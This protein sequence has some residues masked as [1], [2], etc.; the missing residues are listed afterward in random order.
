MA[1]DLKIVGG[2]VV[3]GRGIFVADIGVTGGRITQIGDLGS[4][5]ARETVS[6]AG[7]HILPGGIDTQV[8]FRE[9][10][11]EHKEDIESGTRS[12]I[13]GG[14][15]TI[16]EM[17]NTNPA[18]T[19]A[20]ALSDKLDRANGRAWCD[21]AF[22]VGAAKDNAA[23]LGRLELLPGTPGVKIFMGSSTG[24]LLVDDD[25]SLRQVLR[26]YKTRSPI[27]AEDEDR[28]NERKGIG[29]P[30]PHVREHPNRRDP[31]C[32]RIA[33]ERILRLS[34]ETYHPVHVLHISTADE[35]PLLAEAKRKG[36]RTTCEVTPQH[37]TLNEEAYERIGTLAQMNP[38]V[39]DESHRLA[40]WKAV[41][42]G[43]FD[44][45]GSDH[46]PHTLEEKSK[47]FP[48]SP[49]GMPGVQTMLPVFLEW[50]HRG[51]LPLIQLVQMLCE[52]PA[53]LYGIAGKGRIE[54]GF[55]ADL[56]LVDLNKE[57]TIEKDWLQSKCGWSPFE[58][59]TVHGRIE[60]VYL[61]G[62]HQVRDRELV[63]TQSGTP[64]KFDW[65]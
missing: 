18:T 39:R 61:R 50:V 33:T 62:E 37:L 9:P 7:L 42:K 13:M 35:L 46:A 30:K 44:V 58:G 65:K 63:G 14:I 3:T 19:T 25:E 56:V 11:L 57:W 53:S 16:F 47:P 12:A 29:G 23:E 45:F 10:G 28:L 15:T 27:H 54:E 8:H 41:K 26:S 20:E 36:L 31:E 4:E 60:H 6:A 34:A 64:V 48:S 1:F 55:D 21:H 52:N 59:M 17:P 51:E 49:S 5:V 40:L 43:L 24:S 38:P 22:F 32:A 2:T